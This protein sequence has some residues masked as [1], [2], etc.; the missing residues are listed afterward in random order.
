MDSHD[1]NTNLTNQL[2]EPPE[3]LAADS[4]GEAALPNVKL[5]SSANTNSQENDN[6]QCKFDKTFF[7]SIQLNDWFIISCLF[8]L[9]NSKPRSQ[10]T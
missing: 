2:D 9:F 3:Q 10:R 7:K 1:I 8:H 6:I 5:S 4:G